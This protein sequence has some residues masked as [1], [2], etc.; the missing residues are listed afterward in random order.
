MVCLASLCI[1]IHRLTR[2]LMHALT[3]YQFE[4]PLQIWRC[5]TELSCCRPSFTRALMQHKFAAAELFFKYPR[6]YSESVGG[7][8]V[9]PR[10]A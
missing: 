6:V 5:Y 9:R 8:T 4:A 1:C 10:A 3:W 7:H 2:I